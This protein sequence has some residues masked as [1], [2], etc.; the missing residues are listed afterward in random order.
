MKEIEL[1]PI[2]ISLNEF[3]ELEKRIKAAFLERLYMP[4]LREFK[5]GR[6][7]VRNA[8]DSLLRAIE[9]GRITYRRGVFRGKL[10]AQITKNLKDLGAR[11]DQRTST[12]RLPLAQMPM[13]YRAAISTSEARFS[14]K[15]EAIDRHLAQILPSEIAEAIKSADLF[16]KTLWTVDRDVESTLEGL[17]VTAK[18]TPAQA[19]KIADEWQ[20]NLGISIKS[21]ADEEILKLRE[22]V[23]KSIFA[24]NRYE[25]LVGSIQKS[26]GVTERK[27]KFLARQETNLLLTKFKETRYT[28]AGVMKY[29]WACVHMPKDKTPAQH[30]PGNVRYSHAVLDG[31][32][33]SWNDPPI[34]SAPNEPQRRNNPGADY[35]CRCMAIPIVDFRERFG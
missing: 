24:G 3:D 26:Y 16:D 33:F 14:E 15:L 27:A 11:W 9:S 25:S 4:V 30:T 21:F 19:Q 17:A 12:F 20:E 7:V 34:T 23:R 32:V 18:L 10:N 6:L 2:D 13:D 5:L 1:E 29:R 31:K 35:N 22:S 8:P 28:S